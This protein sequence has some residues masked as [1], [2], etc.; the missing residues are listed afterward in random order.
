MYAEVRLVPHTLIDTINQI[1]CCLCAGEITGT[2]FTEYF[3]VNAVRVCFQIIVLEF[4]LK[5][6]IRYE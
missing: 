6:K 5:Q 1:L 2:Q 4:G 3:V